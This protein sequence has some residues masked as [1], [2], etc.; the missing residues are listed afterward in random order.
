M[1]DKRFKEILK[2]KAYKSLMK[3][4]EGQTTDAEDGI[5]E[6]DFMKWFYEQECTD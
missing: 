4:M 1:R 2:P 3:F 5:Y 6:W